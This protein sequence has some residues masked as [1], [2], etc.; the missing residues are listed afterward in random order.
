MV[1]CDATDTVFRVANG[2]VSDRNHSGPGLEHV[3]NNGSRSD[4][5][6]EPVLLVL[7]PIPIGKLGSGSR[8]RSTLKIGI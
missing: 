6:P 7:D 3:L 4:F 1:Y 8:T 2:T 5:D